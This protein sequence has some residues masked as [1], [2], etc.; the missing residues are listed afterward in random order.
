MV[1][2]LENEI[3][4]YLSRCR[5]QKKLSP[6]SEKAYRIDLIQF[7]EFISYET[8][9]ELNRE[10]ISSFIFKIQSSYKPKTV[11]RKI[12]SLRAFFNNLVFEGLLD[13]NPLVRINLRFREPFVLPKTIALSDVQKIFEVLYSELECKSL[14]SVNNYEVIIRDIAI[15]ELLF[16]TGIRISELCSLTVSDINLITGVVTIHGKGAKERLVYIGNKNV[17]SAIR[18]YYSIRIQKLTQTP[19]FFINRLGNRLSEQ[20]VRCM[21]RRCTSK[22]MVKQHITPHMFRH[23]FA[24]LLLDEGVDIRYIQKILGHTSIVTTQ[25][26]THVSSSKQKEILTEKNPRNKLQ[27]GQSNGMDN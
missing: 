25:I 15:L 18:E 20:S 6:H 11:K 14:L 3:T 1:I 13:E 10:N 9:G 4:N 5:F 27:V 12:A 19:F 23:S 2:S 26:Y 22:A 24:T 17:V 21:I 16:S 7:S 8:T